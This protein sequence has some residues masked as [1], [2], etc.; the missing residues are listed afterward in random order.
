MKVVAYDTGRPLL[1]TTS[2]VT[3]NVNRNLNGPSVNPP[4]AE[5]DI[6]QYEDPTK[7]GYLVNVTDPDSVSIHK[8]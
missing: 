1:R 6:T 8:L 4:N 5:I 3:I 2:T 7:W